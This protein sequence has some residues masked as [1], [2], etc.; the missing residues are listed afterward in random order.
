MAASP[1][2]L[3]RMLTRPLAVAGLLPETTSA[4]VMARGRGALPRVA[5]SELSTN[6][7]GVCGVGVV[8]GHEHNRYGLAPRVHPAA[9]CDPN[10]GKRTCQGIHKWVPPLGSKVFVVASCEGHKHTRSTQ[11]AQQALQRRSRWVRQTMSGFIASLSSQVVC[12]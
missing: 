5:R 1:Q 12:T 10:H 3:S 4:M 9:A 8:G 11:E 2:P 7:A 6:S